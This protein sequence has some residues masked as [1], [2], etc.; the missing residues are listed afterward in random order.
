MQRLQG[1]DQ[2]NATTQSA[3]AVLKRPQSCLKSRFLRRRAAF[4]G[5]LSRRQAL[6][7]Q[8]AVALACHTGTHSHTC[9]PDRD[10]S[11]TF[12]H[13]NNSSAEALLHHRHGSNP[14]CRHMTT[15]A[16]PGREPRWRLAKSAIVQ[17]CELRGNSSI[18]RP[19]ESTPPITPIGIFSESRE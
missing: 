1:R 7:Q 19:L 3:K 18:Q 12:E 4:R 14:H 11:R 5:G 10:R 8:V 2:R 6:E 15:P 16:I 9:M 17:R 13:H